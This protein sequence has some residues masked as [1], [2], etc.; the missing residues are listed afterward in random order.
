MPYS[1]VS[2]PAK[3]YTVLE[4]VQRRATTLIYNI[5]QLDYTSTTSS[6]TSTSAR[7][8]LVESHIEQ[9]CRT[10]DV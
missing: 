2:V 5:G 7:I 9:S 6:R 3:G 8:D 1:L 4:R 10:G